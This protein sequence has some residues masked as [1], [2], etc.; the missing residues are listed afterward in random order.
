MGRCLSTGSKVVCL[1]FVS[2]TN[3]GRPSFPCRFL[4]DSYF[5]PRSKIY[6]SL[7]LINNM[8]QLIKLSLFDL[9]PLNVHLIVREINPQLL[10]VKLNPGEKIQS[11]QIVIVLSGD[12]HLNKEFLNQLD[13]SQKKGCMR[14][15]HMY[16]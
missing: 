7:F 11:D 16:E 15:Y 5:W 1:Q 14:P 12:M 6:T 2:R 8:E 4:W 3:A 13:W 10:H 9:E